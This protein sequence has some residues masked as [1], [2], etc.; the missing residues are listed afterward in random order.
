MVMDPEE[1]AA[2]NNCA[3]EAQMTEQ[4]TETMNESEDTAS[5]LFS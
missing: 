2:R 5:E 3:G 1:I 4:L